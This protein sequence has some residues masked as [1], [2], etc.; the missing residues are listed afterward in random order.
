[1]SYDPHKI[2]L[3]YIGVANFTHKTETAM[4]FTKILN[5]ILRL[6]LRHRH[7]LACKIS[8]HKVRKNDLMSIVRSFV[9]NF[10]FL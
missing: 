1:M 2:I 9:I 8:Y 6:H 10:L 4:A 5:K 7:I 3:T